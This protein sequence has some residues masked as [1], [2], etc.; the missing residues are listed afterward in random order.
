MS[1]KV[2]YVEISILTKDGKPHPSKVI[3]PCKTKVN[4]DKLGHHNNLACLQFDECNPN[5]HFDSVTR[6]IY[7]TITPMEHHAQSKE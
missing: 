1:D 4:T 2:M 6:N 3:V 5:D 7:S